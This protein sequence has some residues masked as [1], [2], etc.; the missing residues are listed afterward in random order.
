MWGQLNN[1]HREIS[2]CGVGMRFLQET[3]PACI[4]L[5]QWRNHGGRSPGP[6][7]L[8]GW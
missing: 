6:D 8:Q 4:A 3:F 1:I 5:L 2:N 7:T